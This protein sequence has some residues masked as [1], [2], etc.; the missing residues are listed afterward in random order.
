MESF[1][2]AILGELTSRS[3]SYF[4][5]KISGPPQVLDV[6][7]RLCRVLLRAQVIIDE[8]MGR[9]ITNKTMIQQ[10]AML[11]DAM[12]QGFYTLDTFRY[13]YHDHEKTKG[14]YVSRSSF[15]LKVSLLSGL[16]LF[17][18]K[19]QNLRKIQEE[20][21]KLSS[22]ILDLDELI[23]LLMSYPRMFQQP[24]SKHIMLS[25]CMFG[26]QMEAQ[27]VIHFL[28]H[29]RPHGTQDLEVLPIV[30]PGKV[31]KSTF[32]AHVCSDERIRDHFAEIV[33]LRDHD[34]RD[35]W[36]SILRDGL[37]VE[38]R[39]RTSKKDKRLLVVIEVAGD[40]NDD[41]W[42]KLSSASKRWVTNGTKIVITSRSDKIT[43]FGTTG[44]ITLNY[45]SDEAHW[46]FFKTLT[47]GSI[48]PE[49]H[50]RLANL[51]MEIAKTH[52]WSLIGANMD[53]C[54]LRD[55]FDIHFWYKFLSFKSQVI[56]KHLSKFG[57]HPSVALNQTRPTY[58]GRMGG[59]SE[60]F[61]VYDQYQIFSQQEVPKITFQDVVYG[62][63]KPHGKFD[64]LGS[65]RRCTPCSC[66]AG[67]CHFKPTPGFIDTVIPESRENARG[68]STRRSRGNMHGRNQGLLLVFCRLSLFYLVR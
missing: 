14:Q 27:L 4:I 66:S 31:G 19:T 37:S 52:L 48:D 6:E 25:N 62:N 53:A 1:V 21:D 57:E 22:I 26:R 20:F 15:L 40:I 13:Q 65:T 44:V 42:K 35:E 7:N 34:F 8:A 58:L 33:L 47:F 55:N 9:H 49:Q 39:N 54:L 36:L 11:R 24:Y 45:F 60:D 50:P 41:A 17:S 16:C 51:A 59:T 10:L 32:V 61:F 18:K 46:Y 5:N 68:S 3:I 67:P 12:L 28:L 23:R 38:H 64:V 63:V 43:R 30:G 2:S 29:T 56:E